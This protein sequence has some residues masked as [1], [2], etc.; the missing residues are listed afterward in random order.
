MNMENK[1]TEYKGKMTC[2][3]SIEQV[4][5]TWSYVLNEK[6]TIRSKQVENQPNTWKYQVNSEIND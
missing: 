3:S 1:K 6:T 5:S 2:T 4:N